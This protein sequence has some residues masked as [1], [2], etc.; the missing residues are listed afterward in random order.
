M[1]TFT[2]EV[3]VRAPFDA[4]WEFHSNASGLEALTPAFMELELL[5][6]RGPDGELDPD[7]LE[8][9]A[10]IEM[11]M[12]PFGVTPA[13]SWT[14]VIVERDASD[15]SAYFVDEMRDGPFREWRHTHMFY[16]DGEDTIVRDRVDYRLPLGGLGDLAGPFAKVGFEGMFRDRHKRTKRILE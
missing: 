13:Q 9:G 5:A 12:R 10:E 14:S 16:A 7:V 6:V 4:V 2:R 8:T 15:G 1:P 3:R 11:R